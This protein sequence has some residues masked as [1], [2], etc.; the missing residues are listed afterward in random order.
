MSDNNTITVESYKAGSTIFREG[1][2]HSHFYI[3][4]AGT[5]QI[6]TTDANQKKINIYQIGEGES[7]GEFA[8]LDKMPRSASALAVTD[9]ELLK[10]S[11][12]GYEKLLTELPI[13]ASS[14][15]KSFTNRLRVMNK[16]IRDLQ[17]N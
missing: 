5:V 16:K 13:W 11:E 9:V 6:F 14:M 1:D 3:I 8:L 4:K 15:L 2:L 12:K 10:V 17:N 7:F